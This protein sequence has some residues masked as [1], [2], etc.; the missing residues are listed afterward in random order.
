MMNE[1]ELLRL[2]DKGDGA[3]VT[4]LAALP[5]DVRVA[6]ELCLSFWSRLPEKAELENLTACLKAS[7]GAGERQRMVRDLAWGMMTSPE[8]VVN[9]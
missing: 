4:R 8:F 9:H 6:E 2:L 5:D 1:P 7:S 3:V